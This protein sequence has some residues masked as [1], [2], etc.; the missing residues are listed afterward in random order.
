[1]TDFERLRAEAG[2]LRQGEVAEILTN[3]IDVLEE[4]FKDLTPAKKAAGTK[5]KSKEKK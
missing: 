4:Q 2:M 1:M 5:T 3:L